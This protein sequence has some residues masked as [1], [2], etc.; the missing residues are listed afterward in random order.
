MGHRGPP[1]RRPLCLEPDVGVYGHGRR[2]ARLPGDEA[3]KVIAGHHPDGAALGHDHRS[4]AFSVQPL[5]WMR[6]PSSIPQTRSSTPSPFR[7]STATFRDPPGAIPHGQ[8]GRRAFLSQH[9]PA[10]SVLGRR[11]P[12]RAIRDRDRRRVTFRRAPAHALLG[13]RGAPH[14]LLTSVAVVAGKQQWVQPLSHRSRTPSHQPH[15]QGQQPWRGPRPWGCR[16]PG[17]RRR[18]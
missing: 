8:A 17:F 10:A 12:L 1:C 6:A 14:T 16:P 7:S 9:W 18:R 15:R 11:K 3:A 5:S 13:Q 2:E 4:Q